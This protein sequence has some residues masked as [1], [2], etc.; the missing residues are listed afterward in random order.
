MVDLRDGALL[1]LERAELVRQVRD[2]PAPIWVEVVAHDPES[3]HRLLQDEFGFHELAVEDALSD[4]ERPSV[5][6]YDGTL[7]LVATA[8]HSSRHGEQEDY[9]EVAFFV[10]PTVLVTVSKRAIPCLEPWFG[11]WL[12]RTRPESHQVGMLL[13]GLLDAIVDDYFPIVD[14]LED[15]VDEIADAVYSGDTNQVRNLLTIKRRL[16]ELRRRL[17]P[18]RDVLNLTLRMEHLALP[19]KAK[20][21]LQDVYDHLLRLAEII[22]T[23]RDT[24]ASILDVHLSTV[25]NNLNVVVKKMTVISTVL[26]TSALIAGIYGMNFDRIPELHWAFG[27]PFA[28]GLMVLSGIAVLALFKWKRWL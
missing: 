27:Y 2:D 10:R 23:N 6:D 15:E 17:G 4:Q 22:D 1:E 20:R 13:H 19:E 12:K 14:R 21:Y 5:S 24:L 16:L 3:A 25:S 11:Q 9:E 26:M 18:L 28:I 8:V 7:F